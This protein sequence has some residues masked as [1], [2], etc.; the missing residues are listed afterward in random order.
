MSGPVPVT[1]VIAA[2][3]ESA[4][5]AACVRSVAWAAEVLVVEND[6]GDDTVARATAA[7]ATVFSHPFHTI[8]GQRNAA[9]GRA[10][11]PWILVLDADER[12]TRR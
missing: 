11:Q 4:H 7:G 8:G 12:A 5:I 6:S 1:V 9:I 3:N 10:G 2:H